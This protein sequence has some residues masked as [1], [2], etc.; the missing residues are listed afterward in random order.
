MQGPASITVTGMTAPFGPKTWVMPT[1]LP[2][3]AFSISYNPLFPTVD[4]LYRRT[5]YPGA[6]STNLLGKRGKPGDTPGP[7]Q[8]IPLHPFPNVDKG[9]INLRSH[10]GE[11]R[12][13]PCTPF[14]MLI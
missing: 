8:G 10:Y 2:N 7:R 1:F 6:S 4:L 14:P 3:N 12:G 9:G 5:L 11:G 13:F